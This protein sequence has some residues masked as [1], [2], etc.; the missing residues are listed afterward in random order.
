MKL[1]E[2]EINIL[3]LNLSKSFVNPTPNIQ[4]DDFI[5]NGSKFIRSILAILYL[6]AQNIEINDNIYKI[7]CVGELIHNSSLL[8]DDVIDDAH[9]RRGKTT[10]AKQF[11]PNISILAG[12]YLLSS[13]IEILLELNNIKITEIFKNCT[14]EMAKA[15]IKQFFLRKDLPSEKEYINI[16]E[17]KTGLLFSSILESCAIF[18]KIDIENAKI[19]GKRF[20]LCF[21]I[22]NDLNEDSAKIDKK[23]NIYTAQ[24]IL[25]IEK[26]AFLL[27]NQKEEMR[28]L[29]KNF[30]DNI[31]KKELE[32][33]IESL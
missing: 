6:R 11:T 14:K 3:K 25:G 5:L 15:E 10:I 27:D 22:K 24:D 29:I 21:Q 4:L 23:N 28:E 7:L 17:Q 18:S 33:L 20:G 1:I 31:Y 2:N 12:D 19:I 16:C 26:T 9:L 13:A 32:G 30:P 8:H